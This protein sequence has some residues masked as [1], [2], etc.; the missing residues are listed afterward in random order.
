[1]GK[2]TSD[3]NNNDTSYIS[4]PTQFKPFTVLSQANCPLSP[5]CRELSFE[6]SKT[7]DLWYGK[8][9][10]QHKVGDT[11]QKKEKIKGTLTNCLICMFPNLYVPYDG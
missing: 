4:R 2:K 11:L 8:H 6:E 9:Q 1:M 3:N 7:E 10:A 5:S